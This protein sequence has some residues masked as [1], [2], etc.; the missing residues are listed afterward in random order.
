MPPPPPPPPAPPAA[1]LKGENKRTAAPRSADA[2]MWRDFM[3]ADSGVDKGSLN[4]RNKL[5]R[6]TGSR[7]PIFRHLG[8][9]T[10]GPVAPLTPRASAHDKHPGDH[11]HRAGR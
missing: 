1:R 5:E 4:C 10:N 7:E 2:R 8:A 11:Q 9:W 3:T 6:G